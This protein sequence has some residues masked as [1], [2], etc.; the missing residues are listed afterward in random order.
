[1][2]RANALGR[3]KPAASAEQRE[4]LFVARRLRAESK[5]EERELR[6]RGTMQRL[7]QRLR[8]AAEKAPRL[9][10]VLGLG[11]PDRGGG[12]REAGA[13][14]GAGGG[15]DVLHDVPGAVD[16]RHLVA[17]AVTLL[18]IGLALEA[19]MRPADAC[20]D[21]RVGREAPPAAGDLGEE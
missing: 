7:A 10:D 12:E 17:R 8:Q 4:R 1:M 19:R 9:I 2:Q 13:E 15:R 5:R 20:L 21:G 18:A 6:L 11:A 3:R 14:P 16:H